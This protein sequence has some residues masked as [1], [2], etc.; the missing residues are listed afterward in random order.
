MRTYA[1]L[2]L[3]LAL[4]LTLALLAGGEAPTY[5]WTGP[6]PL[7]TN[8]PTDSGHDYWPPAEVTVPLAQGWNDSCYAGPEQPVEDA[9]ADIADHVVAIYL[10]AASTQTWYRW[11]PGH[12]EIPDTLTTLNPYDQLFILMASSADWT[13]GITALPTSVDLARGWNSVCYAGVDKPTEEATAN[14]ADDLSILLALGSD[15]MW[16]RYL[17]GQPEIPDTLPTLHM[18]DSVILLVTAE[19]GTTWGFDPP[20]IP[21]QLGSVA[22][23]TPGSAPADLNLT[24]SLPLGE[25]C[26]PV[27]PGTYYGTAM[28]DGLPAPDGT[29]VTAVL[30]GI[31]WASTTTSGGRYVF[32]VPMVMPVV[33]P[34]FPGGMVTFTCDG[35][36]AAEAA[37]WGAGPHEL[38]L[39][40]GQAL[41]GDADGD[42]NVDAVD[43]MFILQY[44][45]A[46]RVGS[47]QCPAPPG[48]VCLPLSDGDCDGDADAVDALFVLQYVVGLRA[49][50]G[51]PDLQVVKDAVI[52]PDG[53]LFTV[54][55]ANIGHAAAN[56]VVLDDSVGWLAD[57]TDVTPSQGFCGPFPG[58]CIPELT[59]IRCWLGDIPTGWE[60]Q[61][62]ISVMGS[63]SNCAVADPED[64][65]R[66]SDET[67]NQDCAGA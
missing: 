51:C 36:T 43:A 19:G 46:L 65:I 38:N 53:V 45:V 10:L 25:Y 62:W 1:K 3:L 54:H 47:E 48:E 64:A 39:S 29:T 28:I 42:G 55:V 60:A 59:C 20:A 57:V 50:L 66:E 49:E 32:E 17:P 31:V 18:F 52:S 21:D 22:V 14:I 40:C 41:V 11:L 63:A 2:G 56:S 23:S 44:I 5:A 7:N 8:A 6:A 37:A 16:R 35:A 13:Q 4:V 12:P 33:P 61:V 34:C 15:Q 58:M 24:A 9:T 27:F 67:N 30:Q 26:A